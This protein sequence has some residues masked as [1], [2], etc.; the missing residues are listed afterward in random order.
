LRIT[1]G[2]VGLAFELLMSK[3]FDIALPDPENVPP[4]ILEERSMELETLKSIY[5]FCE[6]KI[7]NQLWVINLELPYLTEQ[8]EKKIIPE[9][10]KN[11]QE[12]KLNKKVKKEL[13]KYFMKGHCRYQEKCRF[14]HEVP[15]KERPKLEKDEENEKKRNKFEMEIRFPSGEFED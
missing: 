10:E 9:T 13:C 3:Y 12:K 14:S 2:D 8:Y 5:D 1:A 7:A 15:P 6:E 4:D 11:V